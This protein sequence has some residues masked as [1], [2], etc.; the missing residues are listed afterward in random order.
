MKKKLTEIGSTVEV[1]IHLPDWFPPV[2]LERRRNVYYPKDHAYRG[3]VDRVDYFNSAEDALWRLNGIKETCLVPEAK[4]LV[5][6]VSTRS[7]IKKATL[8]FQAKLERFL[9]RYKEA[10]A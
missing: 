5:I 3:Q 10:R 7:D 8:K 6:E 9:R 1:T 4:W 2:R